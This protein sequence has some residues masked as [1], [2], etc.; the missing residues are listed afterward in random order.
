MRLGERIKARRLA[1]GWSQR[2]AAERADVAYRTWRRLEQ[3]GGASI[4][5]LAK[6]ATA[7]RCEEGLLELFPEPPA[8]SMDELL[9]R[10]RPKPARRAAP[11][12]RP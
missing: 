9:D 3:E 2:E 4:E 1:M 10:S 11:R 7:L 5:D 12:K 8:T 6:A